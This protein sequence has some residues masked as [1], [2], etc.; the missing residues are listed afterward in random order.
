M[1]PAAKVGVFMLII[2]GILGYFILKIEDIDISRGKGTRQVK[3][4]FDNVAGLDE[5][6]AVRVAGVRKGKV[7][8]I[9]LLPNGKAE[10][11]L[12]I[13]D[14]VPMRSN[15]SAH[16]A[17]LGLLGEK[18][19]ELDPGTQ[20][21]PAMPPQVTVTLR[22]T[23][24]ASIDDVTNQISL[25]AADVKAITE[26]LRHVMA[27]PGGQERL[28][29][30]V[31]NVRL[32]TAET[33]ELIAAN[34][35]NVDATVGNMR[36]ITADLRMEIP[37]LAASLDRVANQIGGTV[38]ENREDLRRVVENLRTL[39]ADLK[40]TTTNLNDITGQVK[41]G[42]GTVGKLIYSPEAHERLTSALASVDTGVTELRTTLGRVSKI[43]MDLGLKADYMAGLNKE[44]NGIKNFGG[45]SRSAATLRLIPNVDRNRFYNIELADDPRGRKREKDTILT[46]T[47]P[48]TG[49]TTTTITHETRFDRDFRITAQ[50]GWLLDNLGLRVGLIDNT[51]GVGADYQFNPRVRLTGEAFD[52]GQRYDNSPHFRAYGEYTLRREKPKTPRLFVTAGVDNPLNDV[53]FTIGGGIRWRDDD[54]KYLLGSIPI[55]K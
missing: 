26:S 37:K 20:N 11:T 19:V 9:R 49:I 12:E 44:Q 10:V 31:E 45:S 4:I 1:S 16:V 2:L 51:G 24:P 30:I 22:G 13:D 47:N 14:D 43:G 54:L 23:S 7:S 35:A 29:D 34:R 25:I 5:K 40:I 42:Q 15:A 33:R 36:A 46:V 52:F 17:N 41:S 38:G 3:V 48:A 28:E 53:A 55:G 8:K 21:A 32:I 27:G 6:S 50:A 18:Y 39:S